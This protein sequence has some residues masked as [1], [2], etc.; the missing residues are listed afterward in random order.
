MTKDSY[1]TFTKSDLTQ[2]GACGKSGGKSLSFPSAWT[3][4]EKPVMAHSSDHDAYSAQMRVL[5]R[6]TN[7][8]EFWKYW[9]CVPQP[10]EL[11][12][13]KHFVREMEGGGLTQVDTLM[14]FR[15]GVRPEWEDPANSSGGHF[16]FMFKTGG[17]PPA[18]LDEFWNN[19]AIGIVSGTVQPNDLVTGIRLLDKSTTGR[20]SCI[21]IEVWF[22]DFVSSE[23]VTGLRNSVEACM[24]RRVDGGTSHLPKCEIKSHSS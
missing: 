22:R 8:E 24:G 19:I 21:R 5:S 7:V 20:N 9:L 6:I 1:L 3:L 15:E 23:K 17:M 13:S 12:E 11:L 16:Q 4:W 18:Q 14:L 10:S 2:F